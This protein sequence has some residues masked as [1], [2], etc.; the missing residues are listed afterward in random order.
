VEGED[1]VARKWEQL[2]P[3]LN[4]RQRRLWAAVEAR[5]LGRGGI[6]AVARATGLSRSTVQDAVRELDAGAEVTERVR[7][8]GAGRKPLIDEDRGLLLALDDLEPTA[9]GD[10]MSPLRWT[11]KSVR[12]LAAELTSQ[13]HPVSAS[14]VGQLLRAMDYSLQA[15]VKEVEGA[16]HGDRDAQF[17]HI[18]DQAK[19]HLDGGQPVISIDTK[20][21][22]VVGNLANKGREYRP[23]GDPERVDVH[24]FP[25]KEIGKAIPFGVWDMTADEGFVVVGD[26]HDTAEFAVATIGRWWDTVGSV[27]YPKATRLLITAD[28]GGSNSY[29]SRLWKLELAKLAERT[30]LEITVC[31]FPPG[32]S[33]WNRIE[34]RLWSHVSMNWRGRPLISHEVVVNLIGATKTRSG[35]NVRAQLDQGSYPIGKTITDRQLAAVAMKPHSFHGEWNYTVTGLQPSLTL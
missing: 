20:K 9:R 21:K 26:D 18:N 22:E 23:K 34:H 14:K 8:P 1:A 11:A 10:P 12:T 5:S 24:D 33:K 19:Q 17:R 16:Q 3:H 29:R 6:A 2:S 30:G 25:D 4:E 13:G 7:R 35:L 32:T 28:A 15:P 27:S 31:H